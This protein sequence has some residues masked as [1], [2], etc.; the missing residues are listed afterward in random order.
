ML[1]SRSQ[2]GYVTPGLQTST[3]R[4]SRSSLPNFE[5]LAFELHAMVPWVFRPPYL[6]CPGILGFLL[7][8][9]CGNPQLVS[10]AFPKCVWPRTSPG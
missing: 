9:A 5:T 8:L 6:L 3:R 2:A 7:A 4:S 1:S 10:H